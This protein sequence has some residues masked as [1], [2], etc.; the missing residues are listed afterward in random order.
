MAR[1]I[2]RIEIERAPIEVN[3]IASHE[4]LVHH[5][6]RGLGLVHHITAADIAV[7]KLKLIARP[8]ASVSGRLVSNGEPL[9]GAVVTPAV[10][11]TGDYS[12]SLA[13]VKTDENGYFK[14]VLLPG[15]KYIL[16]MEGKPFNYA[17][18]N[19]EIEISPG[20]NLELGTLTLSLNDR[21]FKQIRDTN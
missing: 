7:G 17:R 11:P 19:T 16:R 1:V 2:Q 9:I 5:E 20:E 13:S 6:K 10:A 21:T 15:C 8:C 4:I 14:A 3:N 12:Q 18:F